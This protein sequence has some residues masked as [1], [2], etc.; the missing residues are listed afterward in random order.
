MYSTHSLFSGSPT[1]VVH[2]VRM[3]V[4]VRCFCPF[5]AV[6][7][8]VFC[9]WFGCTYS[10]LAL[11]RLYVWLSFACIWVIFVVVLSVRT[12]TMHF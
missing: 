6:R 10:H 11:L 1:S 3:V 9:G 5:H 7:M 4:A 8:G 12:V 2:S